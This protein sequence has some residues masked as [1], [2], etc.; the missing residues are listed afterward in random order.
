MKFTVYWNLKWKLVALVYGHLLALLLMNNLLRSTNLITTTKRCVREANLNSLLNN[1]DLQQAIQK[2]NDSFAVIMLNKY[3]L[4]ITLNWLCNTAQISDIHNRTLFFTLDSI[5]RNGLLAWYS[6]LNVVTVQI[7]C[8]QKKFAPLDETYMSFF[9][10]RT[11]LIR[12]IIRSGRSVWMLQ[13]DTFWRA[14]LFETTDIIN[15]QS[16]DVLLDQDGLV[17]IPQLS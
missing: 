3:A 14:N 13:P 1:M 8:L 5:A 17:Y 12:T 4:N 9:I 2:M 10:L 16:L 11:N 7:P 6:Y 15:K